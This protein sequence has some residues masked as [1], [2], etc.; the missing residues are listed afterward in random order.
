MKDKEKLKTFES[1][2]WYYEFNLKDKNCEET[3]MG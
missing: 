2:R 1:E 3:V